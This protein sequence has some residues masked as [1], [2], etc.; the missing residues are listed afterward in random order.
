MYV[1]V[2]TCARMYVRVYLWIPC[3]LFVLVSCVYSF[4]PTGLYICVWRPA[5]CAFCSIFI[6]TFVFQNIYIYI[7]WI[8]THA[9]VPIAVHIALPMF[10]YSLSCYLSLCVNNVCVHSALRIY[11]PTH[12]HCGSP[13]SL[14][15]YLHSHVYTF[16]LACTSISRSAHTLIPLQSWVFIFLNSFVHIRLFLQQSVPSPNT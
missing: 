8:C 2:C 1:Y 12:V 13:Q 4:F 14:H 9:T 6:T 11:L 3:N 7:Y 15:P 10:I 16:T 5:S